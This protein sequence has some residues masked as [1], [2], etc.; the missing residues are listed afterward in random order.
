MSLPNARRVN[1]AQN[2]TILLLTLSALLIFAN[3]PLFG[4]LADSSLVELARARWRE[5]AVQTAARSREDSLGLPV[6]V[7]CANG[8]TRAGTDI[9]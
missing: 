3:L 4:T 8:F 5:S 2:V 7:V 9:R 1:R 6:R